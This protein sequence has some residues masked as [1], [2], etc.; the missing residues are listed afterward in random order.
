MSSRFRRLRR[1]AHPVA[2][3][4]CGHGAETHTH[5]RP[6][7]DCGACGHAV[8]PEH[9]PTPTAL[10][11]VCADDQLID[12]IRRR[13]LTTAEELADR[14]FVALLTALANTGSE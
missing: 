6:G 4:M 2:P 11:E 8:C 9:V 5:F 13:D 3:C 12:A 7:T 10:A 1:P 14:E